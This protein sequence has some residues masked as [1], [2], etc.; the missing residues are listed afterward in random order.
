MFAYTGLTASQVESLKTKHHV[1]LTS[2]GR[3]SLPGL[4]TKT[5]PQLVKAIEDVVVAEKQ[6]KLY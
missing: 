6:A 5:V 1:Y 4:T 3:I 2:D